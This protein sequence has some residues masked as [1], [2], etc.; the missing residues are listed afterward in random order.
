[1]K[2]VTLIP[3][4]RNNGEEVTVDELNEIIKMV[5]RRFGGATVENLSDAE[6]HWIDDVD[7]EYHHDPSWKLT[8]ACD[9]ERLAEAERTVREI[10]KMLEQ[11]AMYFEVRYFDGVRLLRTDE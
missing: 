8:V 1:M 5:Y 6:G 2:W 9:R 4:R 11:K 3:K 10:G 7:G